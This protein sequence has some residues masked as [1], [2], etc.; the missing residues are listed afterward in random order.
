MQMGN[1][2][3][4]PDANGYFTAV[5][6]VAILLR[7]GCAALLTSLGGWLPN[8]F[9]KDNQICGN[10]RVIH[11]CI[12]TVIPNRCQVDGTAG[13]FGRAVHA[14]TRTELAKHLTGSRISRDRLSHAHRR[15]QRGERDYNIRVQ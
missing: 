2:Q 12:V 6:A 10:K 15:P 1:L 14:T 9:Q 13:P 8:L 7:R 11:C 5:A 3:Q 4:W